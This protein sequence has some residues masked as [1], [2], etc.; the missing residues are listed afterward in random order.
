M[1][2]RKTYRVRSRKPEKRLHLQVRSPRIVCF[3]VLRF[4]K[5]GCRLGL[6]FGLVGGLV[7]GATTG[8]RKFFIENDEF[9]LTEVSLETNGVLSEGD[10]AELTGIDPTASVFALKLGDLRKTLEASPA[11]VKAD[12]SRRLPGTLRVRVEERVPV[13]WLECRPLGIV[14]KD[15]A[16]GLLVDEK[17]ICFPCP[18]WWDE[19]ARD[20]PVVL[21]SQADEGDVTVGKELRHR[22]ARRAL[23]LV[24]LA[25]AELG[26]EGW[27]LPVVAVRND[28]SLLAVTSHGVLATFGMYEQKRQLE[29]LVT[30]VHHTSREQERMAKVNLLPERNIPVTMAR[31]QG[32]SGEG[33]G[34][35]PE[36]RLERDIRAVLNR[37]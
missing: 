18:Q 29:D 3:G 22:E 24:K 13:A 5:S 11:I 34:F 4:L 36:N 16:T 14:G 32:Q 27:S 12:L 37:S 8:L 28:Y 17:G 9:R 25:N 30:L 1:P 7:W 21:V 20:L 10:F 33:W 23:E 31:G 2:R 35:L 6:V 15:P 26:A 19:A